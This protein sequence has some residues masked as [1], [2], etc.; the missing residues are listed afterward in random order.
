MKENIIN[1]LKDLLEFKTYKDNKVEFTKLFNYIKENFKELKIK[2]YKFNDRCALVVSNID[3][4]DLDLIFCTHCDVVYSDNYDYTED[5][6][7]IYGRGTID[8]KGSVAVCLNIMKDIKSNKKIALFITTDEEIDGYCAEQLSNIYNSKFVIVPDGGSNFDLVVEEKGLMQLELSIKTKTSHAAQ[9]FNGV[10]AILSLVK[11]YEAILEKFPLPTSSKEYIT[12]ITLTKLNGGTSNNQV[13]GE[14]TMTL[15]IRN[16]VSDSQDELV[17]FIK[18]INKDV[19]AK[20][21]I[22]G[23]AFNTDLNN[24]YVKS[25]INSCENVLNKKVNCV[26]CESTSDAIFFADK[27]I[28]TV[29]MNPDGY[30]AHSP[31]E[32][33]NKNSLVTLYN[34]Y[35]DFIGDLDE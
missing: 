2:E 19:E 17:S 32:Y 4:T 10:N 12:S 29:I 34:I 23:P 6:D 35:K 13:P 3:S 31:K 27:G 7:N 1:T 26:G 11:V 15:D 5:E 21:L 8:M 9:P 33:V 28:P 16:V 30:Y 22:A 18:S 20:V 24:K 14:A 25:Y